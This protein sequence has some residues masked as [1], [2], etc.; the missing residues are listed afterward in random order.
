MLVTM[1]PQGALHAEVVTRLAQL[2]NVSVGKRARVR[3]QSPFALDDLSE[4]EPDLA[5]VPPQD[6]AHAH[7]SRAYLVIEVAA[8][9]LREDREKATRY[10][11]AGI[12]EFWI[13]NLIARAI[14]VH[15]A[16]TADGYAKVTTHPAA[17]ILRPAAFPDITVSVGDI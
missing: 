3:V 9:S 8:A 15:L 17:A 7:P 2:L 1:S 14:E 4:P 6:Y 13:V 11:R 5:L 12:S 16:P 10:A